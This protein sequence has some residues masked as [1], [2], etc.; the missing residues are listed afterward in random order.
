[1][2]SAILISAFEI[3]FMTIFLKT[4]FGNEHFGKTGFRGVF[5]NKYGVSKRRH[6]VKKILMKNR[7][8]NVGNASKRPPERTQ[9]SEMFIQK[10][11]KHETKKKHKKN[12]S[13][14]N[15]TTS[16]QSKVLL[17]GLMLPALLNGA[18]RSVYKNASLGDRLHSNR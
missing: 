4:L 11:A 6:N 16:H 5:F 3:I 10:T 13:Q 15:G 8:K 18:R 12:T 1:M 2:A 9:N 7:R 14:N 17:L